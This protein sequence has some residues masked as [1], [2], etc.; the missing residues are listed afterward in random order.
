MS[1]SFRR[2]RADVSATA[3]LRGT[4]AWTGGITLTS[5]GLRDLDAILGG[6]QP[7][8]TCLLIEEDRWTRDLALCFIRYWCAEVCLWQRLFTIA[9]MP[10]LISSHYPITQ[11]LSHGQILLAPSYKNSSTSPP[12]AVDTLHCF[13]HHDEIQD[14]LETLPRNL[15]WDKDATQRN[16]ETSLGVPPDILEEDEEDDYANDTAEKGLR[17]AWQYRKSVQ[18]ERSGLSSSLLLQ[19]TVTGN[20]CHSFDLSRRMKEQKEDVFDFAH[21]EEISYHDETCKDSRKHAMHF[22]RELVKLI[23]VRLLAYKGSVIRILLYHIDPEV[24]CVTLPLLLAHIRQHQYPVAVMVT[25]KAWTCSSTSALLSL[26]RA[27]DVVLQTEG[28]ASRAVYPPP[29][30]F[31]HLHG[32][33]YLLKASTITAA[34]ANG[35][36]HFA[37]STL[38]KRATAQVYG[39]KRD[40]RKLNI[41]LLHIPPEDHAGNGSVSNGA[42][43]SGAGKHNQPKVPSTGCDSVEGRNTLLDF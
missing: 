2:K 5:V 17:I 16:V 7:L 42:V 40:K 37:D 19:R 41:P 6:G 38:T 21:I 4:K 11:A 33:L 18:D 8:G 39:L 27:C 35:A 9:T 28:F 43:R 3:G 30:E 10:S 24:M 22:L 32:L 13:F 12:L 26:R 1:S 20:Y 14:I 15:H 34:T 36:G 23:N 29:P 31:R 25:M